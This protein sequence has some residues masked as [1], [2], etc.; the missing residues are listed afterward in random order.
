M[1]GYAGAKT[2]EASDVAEEE[3]YH[4]MTMN[5]NGK[6]QGKESAGEKSAGEESAGKEIAGDR[7]KLIVSIIDNSS[8]SVIFCQELPGKFEKEVVP[9]SYKFVRPWDCYSGEA[10]VAV[11]WRETDFQ[12]KEV[13]LADS[14]LFTGIVKSLLIEEK[15]LDVGVIMA[16]I[17]S[18][19]VKL[20]SRKNSEA[21]FLAVSWHGPQKVKTELPIET[22]LEVFYGLI[23]LLRAVCEMEKLSWLIIGGDFNF[24]TSKYADRLAEYGVTIPPH[25]SFVPDIDNVFVFSIH[26]DKLPMTVD[27]T[28]SSVA[29]HELENEGG[30][31]KLLDNLPVTG[32]LK[33]VCTDKKPSIKQDKGKQEQ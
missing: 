2:T 15:K 8:A 25:D 23:R 4:I 7:R 17:R 27:I 19:M 26:S 16:S 9:N 13:N 24:N 33:V 20:T 32:D 1:E 11:M 5:M 6:S 30:K 3:T 18:A 12:G 22:K 21:S 29:P 28:V 31:R 14:S 10:K